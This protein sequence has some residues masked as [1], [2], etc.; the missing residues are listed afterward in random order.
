MENREVLGGQAVHLHRARIDGAG[1][2]LPVHSGAGD[3]GDDAGLR[4]TGC[5]RAGYDFIFCHGATS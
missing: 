1:V 3:P 2:D 4:E 5:E